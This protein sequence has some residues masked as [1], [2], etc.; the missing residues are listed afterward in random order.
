MIV[1]KLIK[2]NKELYVA[3]NEQSNTL[4]IEYGWKVLKVSIAN[5]TPLNNQTEIK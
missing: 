2:D 1:L 3:D 4:A 5:D